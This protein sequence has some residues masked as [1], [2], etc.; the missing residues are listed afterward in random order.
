VFSTFTI[1]VV[2][3]APSYEF[4]T[5]NVGAVLQKGAAS[6]LTKGDGY[7]LIMDSVHMLGCLLRLY[8]VAA[9]TLH[10]H[11]LCFAARA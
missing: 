1:S 10:A 2:H 3:F 11:D 8:G 4:A 7:G 6:L 5:R 9:S